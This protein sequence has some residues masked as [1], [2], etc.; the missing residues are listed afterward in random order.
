MEEVMAEPGGANCQTNQV[1]YNLTRRGIE[2]DLMPWSA[3]HRMPIMAYSPIE[4]GR[5]ARNRALEAIAKAHGATPAQIAL[6]FTLDQGTISIPKASREQHVRENFATLE[7]GLSGADREAL[8]AAF[9][10]PRGKQ[11][12]DMI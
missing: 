10:P 9:P 7:I 1:L 8:D 5:L 4:Q 3:R 6:K 11:P 12:L 2:H